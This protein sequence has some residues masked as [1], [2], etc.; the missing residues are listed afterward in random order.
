VTKRNAAYDHKLSDSESI[1]EAHVAN[2][3]MT[4]NNLLMQV[5]AGELKLYFKCLAES[6]CGCQVGSRGDCFDIVCL[7][8]LVCEKCH[9]EY[10]T[11][12]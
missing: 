6:S 12:N 4:Q 10:V 8:E 5:T 9:N 3:D 7:S 1:P 2:Q 11:I